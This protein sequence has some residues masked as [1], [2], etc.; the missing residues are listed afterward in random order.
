MSPKKIL[1]WISD[2][3]FPNRCPF[4][5]E[6]ILWD[7]L[8]CSECED[9]LPSTEFE[10]CPLCGQKPCRCGEKELYYK[11]VETVYYYDGIVPDGI[12][13]LKNDKAKNLARLCALKL[14]EKIRTR[15]FK[16]D[17]IVPV[18]MSIYKKSVRGYNQ[19]EVI[20]KYLSLE[21]GV[22]LFKKALIRKNDKV[23]Q[24]KLD[25]ESRTE[26]VK[27]VF[28]K[29]KSSLKGRNVLLCDDVM[30]TG[31]TVNYCAKLLK[32]LGADKVYVAV[33]AVTRL[34][35]SSCKV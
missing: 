21:L 25:A 35:K 24:H 34:E 11:G 20:G 29:G 10:L 13:R 18:P 9:K 1:L 16:I 30:T 32:E 28:F 5:D 15:K 2:F 27:S 12:Y 31:S 8:L 26:H 4:C 7:E 23:V 33:C 17:G 19:A 6:I 22:P 3:F 14:S